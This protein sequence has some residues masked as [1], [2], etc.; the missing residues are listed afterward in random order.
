M[1]DQG[2]VD[3]TQVLSEE[4]VKDMVTPIYDEE[5][6]VDV[7]FYGYQIWMG[8]TDDGLDFYFLRGPPEANT[9]F[10][11]QKKI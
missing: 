10:L 7:P 9:S 4:Y 2:R 6:G 3:S 11:F 5:L 1:L 8:N